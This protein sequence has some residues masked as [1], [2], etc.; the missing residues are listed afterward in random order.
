MKKVGITEEMMNDTR[1]D[2]L[3]LRREWVW[4]M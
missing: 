3:F 1:S 4:R 2:T